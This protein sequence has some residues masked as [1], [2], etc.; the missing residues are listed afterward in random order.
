MTSGIK[1]RAL[2][3]LDEISVLYNE[4]IYNIQFMRFN[5]QLN[6]N[7][8]NEKT[9]KYISYIMTLYNMLS[10]KI[11]EVKIKGEAS[12][13][14]SMVNLT[15]AIDDYEDVMLKLIGEIENE[16]TVDIETIT[17]IFFKF[18]YCEKQ[19]RKLCEHLGYTADQ[20][21]GM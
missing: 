15:D 17:Q 10:P 2:L 3:I 11:E 8:L 13:A 19:L 5:N 12:I 14:K 20:F 6:G 4:V 7:D 9:Y 18:N 1:E 21:G 16:T